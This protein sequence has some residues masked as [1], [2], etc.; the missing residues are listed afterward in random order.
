MLQGT[1]HEMF[2]HLSCVPT[3]RLRLLKRLCINTKWSSCYGQDWYWDKVFNLLQEQ[4][5]SSRH[6]INILFDNMW[7]NGSLPDDFQLPLRQL[8]NLLRKKFEFGDLSILMRHGLDFHLVAP[9]YLF[10]LMSTCLCNEFHYTPTLP[11][12]VQP[13]RQ[14]A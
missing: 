5:G 12:L 6:I 10:S 11:E 7:T 8:Y 13:P 14:A 4:P 9:A 2:R 1:V 3:E